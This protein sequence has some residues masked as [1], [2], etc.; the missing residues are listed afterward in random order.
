[1]ISKS[2]GIYKKWLDNEDFINHNEATCNSFV[3]C[4]WRS[5]LNDY[6]TDRGS[7]VM[8]NVNIPIFIN[9]LIMNMYFAPC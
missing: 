8:L 1:M 5:C 7:L 6:I 2:V 9:R 3:M 4:I